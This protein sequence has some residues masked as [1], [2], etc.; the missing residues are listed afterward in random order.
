MGFDETKARRIWQTVAMVPKGKVASYGQIADLA[1]LPGRARLVGKVLGYAPKDMTLP[2]YRILRSNGQL[3]FSAGSNEA[4][5]QKGLLQEEGVVVLNN[6]VKIKDFGWQPS[7]GELL[8]M[9][10]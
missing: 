1:G 8:E 7:L 6:R 3:A 10:Y 4:E 9:K 2:W 5:K